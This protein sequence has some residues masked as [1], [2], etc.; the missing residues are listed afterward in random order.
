MA[1]VQDGTIVRFHFCAPLAGGGCT[2]Q[3][4][5]R[6]AARRMHRPAVA[7]LRSAPNETLHPP[8]ASSKLVRPPVEFPYGVG[9]LEP[10]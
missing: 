1:F 9:G 8:Y 4:A 7:L 2:L 5:I 3:H 10:L 6:T